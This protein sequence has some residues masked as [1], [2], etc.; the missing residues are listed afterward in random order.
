MKGLLC[1]DWAIL[2]NSYKKN[3]LI[4]VVLYL[5][6]AVCL[7]MNYLC[8]ALVAVCGVYASSTMNFDDYA[9]WD[10]YARTLP[11]TPG[12]VVGCKYLLGLLLTLFGSVCAAVGIFLTGQ[13]TD[14][15]EAAF[16][17][18]LIAAFSLLLFAVNMPISKYLLPAHV[19]PE[20]LTIM[21]MAFA[22]VMFWIVSLFTVKEK[23]PLKD[24]GML[25]VCALCGVGINQGLF[26][27]GLNRSSPVDASIIATAV[28]IFVLL[29]AAVILKE[30]ITRKKSFGV[31][32]GVS[33]GLLLVFSSTHAIDSITSLDGD[34]MM[35]VSGLMYAIYLVLSKPLSLRYSSVTMMKWMFLFTTLTL[36]PFTFRHVLDAPAFHRE[37]WDFTELGA[38]FYVLF[39]A[40][41][42][43]YLLIPMSLKR[44]RPTTVSMYN[45]VQPIVASFI[46]VM[47][48]Q[49]TLS[50]QKV[51]SAVL[52]FT[53]VY[54]VTQSKSREDMEKGKR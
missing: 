23:V 52:V 9:H 17:I 41:F 12:Q 6:M 4:M 25:F 16:S 2:V 40:T 20:G 44:I 36:V 1:K 28:P 34:M 19:P 32:M 13:Y 37:V 30:P 27:V 42:L 31:F 50:W 22:C 39:G 47:I 11:V 10:T 24:L 46:A 35:I 53:G 7:H 3:F 49:D 43:P 18:L 33:G 14:V 15:L 29:L 26:I 21:R 48:G 38:I 54:L 8:Y 51:L 45:Y 5:G